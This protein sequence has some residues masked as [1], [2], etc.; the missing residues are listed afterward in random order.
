MYMLFT[1][2]RFL[3]Q[4]KIQ[5]ESLSN[6][7]RS[8]LKQHI[9]KTYLNISDMSHRLWFEILANKYEFISAADNAGLE[10]WI[11]LYNWVIMRP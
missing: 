5:G 7:L 9:S 2:E 10:Q 4:V 1:P 11:C 8:C 6:I 3:E